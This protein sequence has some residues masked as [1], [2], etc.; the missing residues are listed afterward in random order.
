[1]KY[2]HKIISFSIPVLTVTLFLAFLRIFS[3]PVDVSKENNHLEENG[4]SDLQNYGKDV[5]LSCLNDKT[6]IYVGSFFDFGPT[7]DNITTEKIEEYKNLT[8]KSMAWGYFSNNWF[9][10]ISFPGEKAGVLTSQKVIPFIRL[11]PRSNLELGYQDTPYSLYAIANGD[12]D[13]ELE[14]WFSEAREFKYPIMIEFG[15]E[16]NGSWFTWNGRWNGRGGTDGYGDN[17]IPDGPEVF[18]DAYRRIIDIS[19]K[20]GANNILWIY[21]ANSISQPKKD[22]NSL[23]AYYPGDTYIDIIGL[24][25]YG[26]IADGDPWESFD[27]ILAPAYD[28]VSKTNKP[29]IIAEFGVRETTEKTLW[30]HNAFSSLIKRN[31]PNIVGISYWHSEWIDNDGAIINLKIDSSEDSLSAYNLGISDPIFQHSFPDVTFQ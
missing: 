21:H 15:T 6:S 20:M 31:Y 29:I 23:L 27:S 14:N 7:E 1:M 19:R 11:M 26:S 28:V 18:I 2:L 22:W 4:N 12:F 8:G 10:D 13:D 30:I 3:L 25:V 24:S 9:T 5:L 16:V 17:T